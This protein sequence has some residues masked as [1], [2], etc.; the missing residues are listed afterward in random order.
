MTRNLLDISDGP[1]ADKTHLI[2]DRDAKYC[3]EFR[4]TLCRE[5]IHV[6]RLPPYAEHFV[7]SVKEE[8]LSAAPSAA[9]V[10]RAS[11]PREEPP[12]RGEPSYRH[13][14]AATSP[15]QGSVSAAATGRNVELLRAACELMR[16]S[17]RT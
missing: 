3:D 6:I 13:A 2:R 14:T 15:R 12:R 11:S 17:S 7:R 10:R 5:G 16:R 8:C 4:Q 9:R 1:L